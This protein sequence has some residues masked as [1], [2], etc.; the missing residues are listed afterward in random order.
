MTPM[1]W[2]SDRMLELFVGRAAPPPFKELVTQIAP[3]PMLF[4]SG[5]QAPYETSLAQRYVA[6]A[7]SSAEMWDLPGVDHVSGMVTQPEE[8]T[9]KMLDFF[10]QHLR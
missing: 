2:M 4:I 10:D 5:G 9:Q 1:V 7:G 6:S 8:Y 3:R